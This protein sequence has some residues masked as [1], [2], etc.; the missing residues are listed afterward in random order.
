MA[1]RARASADARVE[2]RTPQGIG[3][4]WA[5]AG[6]KVVVRLSNARRA[7]S[8]AAGETGGMSRNRRWTASG[9]RS[10][11]RDGHRNV[12]L[13]GPGP[14]RRRACARG[15]SARR[16]GPRTLKAIPELTRLVTRVAIVGTGHVGLA[17]AIA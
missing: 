12:R 5:A 17:T 10:R 1:T 9:A 7:A 8:G 3:V 16:G 11:D 2:A 14:V 15:A 4:R 13:H 6:I